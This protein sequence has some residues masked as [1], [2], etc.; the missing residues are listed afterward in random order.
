MN[1]EA[2]RSWTTFFGHSSRGTGIYSIRRALPKDDQERLIS[3]IKSLAVLSDYE[4]AICHYFTW[5]DAFLDGGYVHTNSQDTASSS[6]VVGP[7]VLRLLC[8]GLELVPPRRLRIEVRVP[9]EA[10][11]ETTLAEQKRLPTEELRQTLKA[12]LALSA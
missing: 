12:I 6:F 7:K 3:T 4:F 2:G 9:S 1:Q 11:L 5:A 10:E 8:H